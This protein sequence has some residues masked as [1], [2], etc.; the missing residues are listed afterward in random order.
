[1]DRPHRVFMGT[2]VSL[3]GFSEVRLHRL[4]L[5]ASEADGNEALSG[6]IMA[7]FTQLIEEAFG[8]NPDATAIATFNIIDGRS[9]FWTDA[10]LG[11]PSRVITIA[12][13]PLGLEFLSE[14][15][16]ANIAFYR[17]ANPHLCD[18]KTAF[19]SFLAAEPDVFEAQ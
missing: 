1:M 16:N 11:R 3:L 12:V 14:C 17:D 18:L 15:R 8:V 2:N 19:R 10:A 13:C 9:N 4:G 5:S 6:A 7:E